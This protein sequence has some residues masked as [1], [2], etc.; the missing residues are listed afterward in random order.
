VTLTV[1]ATLTSPRI[2][3][4]RRLWEAEYPQLAGWCDALVGDPA[5]AHAIAATAFTRLFA[6]RR[7]V[8]DQRSWLYLE[9]WALVRRRW[10]SCQERGWLGEAV[11]QLPLHLQLPVL[12]HCY[13][14]LSLRD[15]GHAL[16]M[17]DPDVA[18]AVVAAG[19]WVRPG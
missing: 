12:L 16:G 4:A 15:V 7:V 2:R 6:R 13:A 8:R 3:P 10:H 5:S 18:S 17:S 9:A 11:H 14:E 19:G 1:P